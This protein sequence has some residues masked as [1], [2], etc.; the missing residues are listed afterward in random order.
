MRKNSMPGSF[1][2]RFLLH[3]YVTAWL[4]NPGPQLRKESDFRQTAHS[5]SDHKLT[6]P[7]LAH[8]GYYSVSVR[9]SE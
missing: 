9:S 2:S 8:I 7:R 3:D 4:A 6:C 5:A 1:I